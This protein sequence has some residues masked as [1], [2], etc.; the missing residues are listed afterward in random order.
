[1]KE[2]EGQHATVALEAGGANLPA[3]V[4]KFMALTSKIMTKTTYRV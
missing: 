4:K 3:P 2:D 1:M